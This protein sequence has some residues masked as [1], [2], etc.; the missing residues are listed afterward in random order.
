MWFNKVLLKYRSK[1]KHLL[2]YHDTCK[3]KEIDITNI[4]EEWWIIIN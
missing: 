2:Q 1:Q 4:L 3:L